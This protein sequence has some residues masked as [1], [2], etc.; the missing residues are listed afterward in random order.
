MEGG[1]G[2]VSLAEQRI[3][4]SRPPHSLVEI[5]Q[6]LGGGL[7]LLQARLD[8]LWFIVL[9]LDERLSRLVVQPRR[10]RRIKLQVVDPARGRVTPSVL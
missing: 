4:T 8:R 2:V 3:M 1:G 6:R 9:S 7:V 10:F 5:T